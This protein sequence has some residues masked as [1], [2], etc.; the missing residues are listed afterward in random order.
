MRDV[1]ALGRWYNAI[2]TFLVV[3]SILP[4]SSLFFMLWLL[5]G[6]GGSKA[7][8]G[9][10]PEDVLGALSFALLVL[11]VIGGFCLARASAT[12][13]AYAWKAKRYRLAADA[14]LR[15]SLAVVAAGLYGLMVQGRRN[16]L[17]SATGDWLYGFW[18][19]L[20]WRGDFMTFTC[21][22]LAGIF[23]LMAVY[24]YMRVL[25]GEIDHGEDS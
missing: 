12:P 3:A 15:S 11:L 23:V 21:A 18:T 25:F 1:R 17:F 6:L 24:Q 9:M 16:G 20:S 5:G 2:V 10:R 14:L 19:W 13:P 7:P 4:G 22:A 8:P